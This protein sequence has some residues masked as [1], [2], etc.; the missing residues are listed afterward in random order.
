MTI[1][2][3]REDCRERPQKWG[4]RGEQ[5]I[6]GEVEVISASYRWRVTSSR[7]MMKWKKRKTVIQELKL[8]TNKR[9]NRESAR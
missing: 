8:L 7:I 9:N 3:C 2:M 1:E 4:R 5:I 6:G